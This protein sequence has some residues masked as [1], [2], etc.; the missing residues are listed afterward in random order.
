MPLL[1]PK[2]YVNSAEALSVTYTKPEA[3]RYTRWLATHHYENFH[4]VTFLLPKRLHQDFYNVYAFCRW[5]DDLGD[6]IGDPAESLRLLALVAPRAGGDVRGRKSSIRSSSRSKARR[7]STICRSRLFSDLITAFEQDQNVTRYQNWTALF[8]YCRCSANPVGRLVLRLCGYA[9]EERDRLSDSTCTAL[10]LANFWQDVT[11]DYEK[12][13]VYLPLDLMARHGY[14]V[15]ELAAREFTP[16]FQ[17]VM[18]DAVSVARKL[19]H[20]GLPL[21]KMVD[22]RLSFDLD[23]F[24]R[25]G[26]RILDKIEQ[27]RLQRADCAAQGFQSRPPGSAVARRW[28][29]QRS[30]PAMTAWPTSPHPTPSAAASPAAAPA[31]SIIRSC[32]FRATSATPC[33]RSMPSCAIATT[34]AKPKARTRKPSSAGAIELDLALQG[35]YS[36]N[37]LW[38]AFHDTV[39]RYKIPCQYF[40]EMIDGVSSDLNPR[41]I[42]TFDELYRYCY[43]VASVVG[44][45]IIHIFG[46]ESPEALKLAEKC[47]IAFQLTNILRDVREDSANQRV[48]IPQRR[49]ARVSTPI[50]RSTTRTSS[51]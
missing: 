9:D 15:A 49:H 32:C 3:E 1:A 22:R 4:V 29:A 20:E 14:S 39:Q 50:L 12:D 17:A 24:N 23:L 8:G 13:R 16:A 31:I 37:A 28:C 30:A 10:Q 35:Q 51:A 48:Y 19:F 6:E 21:V 42:E 27:R 2:E 25:G 5:A 45:T 46:F 36:G 44:L 47:G 18:R 43:Q 40:H 11:V 38:P 26:L 7:T 34:S 41:Q 33:A